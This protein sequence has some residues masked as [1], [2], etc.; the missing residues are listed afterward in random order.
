M[1][2]CDEIAH[3]GIVDG[4]L[5]FGL[6]GDKGGG[7]IGKQA[8]HMQGGDIFEDVLCGGYQFATKDEVQGLGHGGNPLH[9][10]AHPKAEGG[11]GEC[12]FVGGGG[13]SSS[14]S[15]KERVALST[16][17]KSLKG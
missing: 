16:D 12:G 17:L 7:V 5:C 13:V 8:H 14:R 2:I 15:A 4:A 11:K 6:P 10:L 1:N 9:G 3:M